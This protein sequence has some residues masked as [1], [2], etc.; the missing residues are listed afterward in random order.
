[1]LSV[2]EALDSEKKTSVFWVHMKRGFDEVCLYPDE[3]N[4]SKYRGFRWLQNCLK[5][6]YF[7]RCEAIAV[8]SLLR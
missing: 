8:R 2:H 1:M 3:E 7:G 6:H 5:S 4:L